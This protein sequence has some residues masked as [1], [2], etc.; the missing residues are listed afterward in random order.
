MNTV[1]GVTTPGAF[2]GP[3][4]LATTN[5]LWGVADHPINMHAPPPPKKKKLHSREIVNF[6][7]SNFDWNVF[8]T[9]PLIVNT[10]VETTS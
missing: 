9:P 7:F 1:V 6:F 8:Y 4:D 5:W 3:G 10:R 2:G